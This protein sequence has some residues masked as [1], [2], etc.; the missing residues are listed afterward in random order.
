MLNLPEPTDDE[1]KTEAQLQGF[2]YEEMSNFEKAMFK[3]TVH[4]ERKFSK[5]AEISKERK[6][7]DAWNKKV[8]DFVEDPQTLIDSPELEGKVEEFKAFASKP[9]RRGVDFTDLILAFN[10][11]LAKTK[12]PA[13]KG[14]MF[15]SKT[16]A[17]RE[18]G[19]EGS[20]KI[21][22]QQARSLRNTNYKEY[23]RLLQ[24][25]KISNQID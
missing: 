25:G 3:K 16:E 5:V 17:R 19:K 15:D 20:N 7:I 22:L 12:K 23:L 9:T 21:S 6:D 10:G 24:S 11:E 13:T 14:K 1:L 4:N 18:K 8:T 2:N